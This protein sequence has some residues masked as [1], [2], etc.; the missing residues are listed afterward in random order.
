MPTNIDV[1]KYIEKEKKE[2]SHLL[3]PALCVKNI[4]INIQR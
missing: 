4:I 1:Y 2:I 3:I